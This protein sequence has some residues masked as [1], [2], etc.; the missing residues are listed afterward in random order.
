[1]QCFIY[2]EGANWT[3]VTPFYD[4][5]KIRQFVIFVSDCYEVM[6]ILIRNFIF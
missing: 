1:M 5:E 6:P 3:K 4:T 2:M